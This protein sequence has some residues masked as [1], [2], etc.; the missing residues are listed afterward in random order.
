MDRYPSPDSR[1]KV[2]T[3]EGE[4]EYL[5]GVQLSELKETH[6]RGRPGKSGDRLQAAA[7]EWR[8]K[9]LRDSPHRG[10]WDQHRLPV[11]VRDGSRMLGAHARRQEPGQAAATEPETEAYH[12]DEFHRAAARRRLWARQLERQNGHQ[13][14]TGAARR[15][16]QQVNH[17]AGAPSGSRSESHRSVPYNGATPEERMAFSEERLTAARWRAGPS[18]PSTRPPC[19]TQPYPAGVSGAGKEG[20]RFPSTIPNS[21]SILSGVGG[22]RPGT[23]VP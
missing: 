16:V 15:T 17:Q 4:E 3:G 20:K 11:A 14:H 9:T 18:W 23:A 19:A 13:T 5:P 22:R 8:N 7:L 1:A 2:G 6:R 10:E 12:R 21:P